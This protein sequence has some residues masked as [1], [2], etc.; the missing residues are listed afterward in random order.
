MFLKDQSLGSLLFL[1][2]IND[3]QSHLFDDANLF[4]K[5]KNINVLEENINKEL[6]MY[7][8]WDLY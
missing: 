7:M 4:C 3:F 6:R 2:Y 1:I 8:S 5:N